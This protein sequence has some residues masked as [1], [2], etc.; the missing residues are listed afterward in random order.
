M[1]YTHCVRCGHELRS[2]S[3]RGYCDSCK[4]TNS[5]EASMRELPDDQLQMAFFAAADELGRRAYEIETLGQNLFSIG[6]KDEGL[7]LDDVDTNQ[8]ANLCG[9]IKRISEN[10]TRLIPEDHLILADV[11]ETLSKVGDYGED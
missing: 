10:R 5:I 2:P 9:L 3:A 7:T 8:D 6:R 11:V 1:V 4:W